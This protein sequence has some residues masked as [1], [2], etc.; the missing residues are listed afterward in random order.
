MSVSV[1]SA[2]RILILAP[3]TDDAELGCG[4][5]IHRWITEGVDVWIA[6]LSD[7]SN[8]FGSDHGQTM[9]REALAA[10]R[11]LGVGEKNVVFGDFPLRSFSEH[12]QQILDFL[13]DLGR[14]VNPEL[15][16][17]PSIGDS[18]QDHG[19]VAQ[20]MRRAFSKSSLIGFD[21]YWNINQQDCSIVLEATN[22]SVEKKIEA[23]SNYKSQSDRPYMNPEVV[24]AQALI[25]GLPRRFAFAEAFSPIQISLAITPAS[26][27]SS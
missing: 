16:V 15:V 23:L 10:A 12:R 13:C 18:H 27:R 1:L 20:E 3:H 22:A 7:T 25:R 24:S 5:S 26:S 11:C 21:T 17:G 2:S 14:K 6:N 4:A 19:V 9:R 8:I